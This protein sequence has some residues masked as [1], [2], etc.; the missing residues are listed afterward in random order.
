MPIKT[1]AVESLGDDKLKVNLAQ[2]GDDVISYSQLMDVLNKG[3]E[4]GTQ[5]GHLISS[6]VTPEGPH[7][8]KHLASA[9]PLGKW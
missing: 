1:T 4:D 5:T 3:N 8:P 9:V 6:L 2:E 7:Q